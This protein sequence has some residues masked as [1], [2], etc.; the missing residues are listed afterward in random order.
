MQ[1][2]NKQIKKLVYSQTL[3]SCS[4]P[5]L[6]AHYPVICFLHGDHRRGRIPFFTNA[7]HVIKANPLP[8]EPIYIGP[9]T[10]PSQDGPDCQRGARPPHGILR[11]A[12]PPAEPPRDGRPS[13][14]LLPET[15][16][17]RR[18][19]R[20]PQ[21][22]GGFPGPDRAFGAGRA[23]PV[24]GAS[25]GGPIGDEFGDIAIPGAGVPA[26][27]AHHRLSADPVEPWEA[28]PEEGHGAAFS[29]A[30]G[31]GSSV[32]N[33]W[34]SSADCSCSVVDLAQLSCF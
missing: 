32:S 17:R 29:G 31:M 22:L 24:S 13:R 4:A 5:G 25:A 19:R 11:G 18:E 16:L 33:C 2:L 34:E 27:S 10:R 3:P 14:H 1:S 28:E 23:D 30:G 20:L 21:N 9:F 12:P 7:F 26:Q 6:S 15:Q 8:P